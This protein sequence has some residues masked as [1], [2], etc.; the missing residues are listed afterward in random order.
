MGATPNIITGANAVF[1][2]SDGVSGSVT[3]DSAKA[4]TCTPLYSCKSVASLPL[5]K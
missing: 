3:M 5:G 4:S 1:T 2:A